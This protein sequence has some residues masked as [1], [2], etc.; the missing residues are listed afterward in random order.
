[1]AA[2]KKVAAAGARF[3]SRGDKSGTHLLE[4][5]LWKQAGVTPAAPWYIE[6]GQGMGATLGIADDRKAYTLSDRGTVL[7]FAK[8]IALKVMVEG[9]RPLLNLY[10]VMEVNPANGPRVNAQGGKTFSDFMLAPETQAVIKTFGVE[11]YGQ[12]LFVPI[13]GKKDEDF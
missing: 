8:R 2:L 3:V 10:S 9:D 5:D 13:A 7:A 1:V 11:K 12:P 6:S 4:Q